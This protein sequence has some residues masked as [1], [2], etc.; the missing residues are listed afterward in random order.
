MAVGPFSRYRELATLQLV[1]TRRGMTRSLA[2]RR[3]SSPAAPDASEHR[4]HGHETVDLLALRY[5]GSEEL[6]WWLLDANGGPDPALLEPGELL[7]VPPLQLV[8]RLPR[9]G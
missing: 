6:Y 3:P 4:L 1:H 5:Y 8:T 2:L 9:S 7:A